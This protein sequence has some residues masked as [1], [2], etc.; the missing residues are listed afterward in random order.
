[1]PVTR[2]QIR[3]KAIELLRSVHTGLSYSE[4]ASKIKEALP[5]ANSHTISG[6]IWNLHEQRLGVIKPVRGLFILSRDRNGA[7]ETLPTTLVRGRDETRFYTEFSI[8]LKGGL[9]DAD[10]AIVLGGAGMRGSWS[11]P[12]V[13][14]AR[15]ISPNAVIDLPPEIVSA[16]IKVGTSSSELLTGFGQACA[17]LLFSNKSYLVISKQTENEIKLRLDSLCGLF[18]LGLI[19]F[20]KD[21]ETNPSFDIKWKATKHEPDMFYI[22]EYLN[23]LLTESQKRELR[24]I[25]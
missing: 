16:E 11:T 19:E 5:D 6:T 21:D 20:D 22:N 14:G 23:G 9:D 10:N 12:D 25:R 15:T 18:G 4:L 7:Q 3:D 17:Y 8:F 2:A 24:L 13:L 1:M